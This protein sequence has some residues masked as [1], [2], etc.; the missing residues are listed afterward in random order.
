MSYKSSKVKYTMNKVV[1]IIVNWNTGEYLAN[2]IN[3][4]AKLPPPDMDLIDEVIVVDNASSDKSIIKAKQVVGQNI[5]KPRVRFIQNENNLGFAAANNIGLERVSQKEGNPHVLLLNP[6]IVV[7]P[8]MLSGLTNVIDTHEKAGIVGAKLIGGNEKL[9][10]SV[11]H[12]PTKKEMVLYMLKLGSMVKEE[13]IDYEVEQ[14]V[15]QVMGAA[16]LI[17]NELL[18]TV[19]NLDDNFFLWFEEVDYCKRAIN[20]GWEVWYTPSAQCTHFGG[21]SFGQLIGFNKTI[22]WLKSMLTYARKHM[23]A[24]FVLILYVLSVVNILLT[25]PASFVHLAKRK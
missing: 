20:K 19:G 14:K 12:F 25:I 21:V 8:G 4:L 15:D 18:N 7:S 17:R 5:N 9:Q 3:S 24:G 22:P 1:I 10:P 16:F 6:D 23:S 13:N 2:C 11:R